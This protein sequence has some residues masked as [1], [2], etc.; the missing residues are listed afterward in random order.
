M[1]SEVLL[2]GFIWQCL[3]WLLNL[4]AYYLQFYKMFNVPRQVFVETQKPLCCKD[5]VD[6]ARHFNATAGHSG[7][8]WF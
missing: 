4:S 6:S 3:F 5:K 7:Y 8:N 1:S 2:S